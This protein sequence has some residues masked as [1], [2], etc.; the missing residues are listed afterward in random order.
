MPHIHD[1]IDFTVDVFIVYE[2]KVLLI[3]HKKHNMWLQVGGH[4]E[5]VPHSPNFKPV[6]T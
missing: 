1:K 5:S 4:I 2:N 3:F 6:A